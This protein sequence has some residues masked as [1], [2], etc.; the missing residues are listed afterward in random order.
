MA[1]PARAAAAHTGALGLPHQ[2]LLEYHAHYS[3]HD[4]WVKAALRRPDF[5]TGVVYR[6][7]QLMPLET[8]Q[9]TYFGQRFMARHAVHD[10][11]SG[12][13]EVFPTDGALSWV[14]FFR[15]KG[16]APFDAQDA[17]AMAPLVAHMRQVLRLHRRL[18]PQLAI[19]MTLREM[20]QLSDLPV[21]FVSDSGRIVDRNPAAQAALEQR[22]GWMKER[23]GHLQ[24]CEGR[25]WQPVASWLPRLR[26]GDGP[27]LSITL[28]DG[29]ARAAT[30]EVIPI[31]AALIDTMSI[32]PAV[33][34]CSLKRGAHDPA[35][36]LQSRYGLTASEAR[37]AVLLAAGQTADD[38]AA[39]TQVSLST[40]RTHL[41]AV[42]RK[43]GVRR[44]AQVVAAV[45]AV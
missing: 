18:A 38:I 23:A 45:L 43:L 11:L 41:A 24:V 30:L 5:A 33:A 14:T 27:S 28:A 2:L 10:V 1:D 16:E 34:V 8:V 6:G 21:C 9:E 36:A 19:G 44:Q 22:A 25:R 12:V 17:L 26:Q 40:V 42:R 20:V 13:V 39:A 4:E 15:E 29:E 37:V 3:A 31:Q 32:H 7:H 35:Q